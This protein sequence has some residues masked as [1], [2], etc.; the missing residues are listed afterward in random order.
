[1][2]DTSDLLLCGMG[3]KIITW[4]DKTPRLGSGV[5]V[6]EGAYI[7][8]DVE[9]GD[10]TSVWFNAVV[11][12]DVNYI[13]IGSRT[14][15]QDG[16]VCHCTLNLYPL[17][18]GSDVTVGHRAVIHGC[19]IGDGCLIGMGAVILDDAE[20]GEQSI[21]A[22]GSVVAPGAKIPSRTLAVGVP[23]KP[24]R[25]VTEEE[26]KEIEEGVAHYMK[27]AQSYMVGGALLPRVFG[28]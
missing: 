1:M 20:V 11:R 12:G 16:A 23:A 7:I 27:L 3:G 21:I 24:K 18:V 26:L 6:A 8:G 5:F 17:I 10:Q 15:I 22:A 4:Q 2:G 28:P 9:I 13:K 25:P 14:S 19:K